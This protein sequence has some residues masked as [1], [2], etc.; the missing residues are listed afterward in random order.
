MELPLARWKTA[1]LTILCVLLLI[2]LLRERR[3]ILD[4][5]RRWMLLLVV[6]MGLQL[7][8]RIPFLVQYQASLNSDRS[9]TLLM[10]R[11]ISEGTSFPLYFYGQ[12]Y[13]GS[14]NAYLYSLLQRVIGPLA[15]S[16]L[17][18][19]LLFLS[20][21]VLFGSMLVNKI[22]DSTSYFY[23]VLVLSLPAGALLFLFMDQVHSFALA[24]CLQVILLYLVFQ[25]LFQDGERFLWMGW[26][27]GLL[28]WS[29]QPGL[30][31]IAPCFAWL[32]A[33]LARARRFRTLS[34][35]SLQLLLGFLV[36][37]L[38][39]LLSELNNGLINTKTLFL[40]PEHGVHGGVAE[41]V[42]A[43]GKALVTALRLD[44]NEGAW[45]GL[46]LLSICGLLVSLHRAL[47]EVK[48]ERL[49]W[50]YLPT[51]L[52]ASLCLLVLSG[53]PPVARYLVHYRLYGFFAVLLAA[54]ACQKIAL[55]QRRAVKGVFLALFLL[56]AIGRSVGAHRRLEPLHQRNEATI[57]KLAE[58]REGIVLGDY[59]NT[60]RFAPF[61][62]GERVITTTPSFV[63]PHAIFDL[64]K[65]YPL[66]LQLGERWGSEDKALMA[67]RH[68]RRRIDRL[69]Q[70]LEI[71]F[72]REELDGY[73]YYSGF[74][75][76]LS[77]ELY[78]LAVEGWETWKDSKSP[79]DSAS[80]RSLKERLAKLPEPEIGDRSIFLPAWTSR[81]AEKAPLLGWRYVLSKGS[82][83]ISVPLDLLGESRRY[84]LPPPLTF[85]GGEYEKH[86]Y[87]LGRPVHFYGRMAVSSSPGD[88]G[89]VLS[90]L[91]DEMIFA[92]SGGDRPHKGLPLSGLALTVLDE[93]IR[94]IDLH[95]YSF[96]DFGSSLWTD[97]Y[98]QSL[99]WERK[100]APLGYQR[101][102]LSFPVTRGE[103]LRLDTAYKTLLLARG[104]T[105]TLEFHDTGAVLEKITVHGTG[106]SYEVTP[107]L[108]GERQE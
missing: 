95:I 102:R 44:S 25:S 52:A 26:V 41:I 19:N 1:L 96:F 93:E 20:V 3:R 56:L 51:L 98:A 78:A 39:H 54:V 72:S 63:H 92:G 21:L 62:G 74:P 45:Y 70:D 88:S 13:Q 89:I 85:D 35:A 58:R 65:Y 10:V 77:P 9:V 11:N 91:R 40:R 14:L 2:H 67:R 28:L 73:V 8:S 43:A 22:T 108:R 81:L 68:E 86:L 66:A 38:P 15:L 50:V 69:L 64:S 29:Y 34:K 49:K 107:F 33:S 84:T 105:R 53:F 46:V 24:A 87:F 103:T 83:R 104:S 61:V 30:A 5:W 60:I 36:G 97:R 17:V 55:M 59:W 101:N 18:G 99:R 6:I 7:L 57:A 75:E 32:F 27:S 42:F 12:L 94:A 48:G 71:P 106:S 16:V 100:E 4:G 23:P 76:D 47:T 79:L 82:T 90:T 80:Y 37:A 31:L